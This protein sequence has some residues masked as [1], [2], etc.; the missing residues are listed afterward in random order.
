MLEGEKDYGGIQRKKGGGSCGVVRVNL[1]SDNASDFWHW[2]MCV[3]LG[4]RFH[5]RGPFSAKGLRQKCT[6]VAR[7]T[8]KRPGGWGRASGEECGRRWGHSDEYRVHAG[9]W[10]PMSRLGLFLLVNQGTPARFFSRGLT[11]SDFYLVI[12]MLC[13][14]KTVGGW[15]WRKHGDQLGIY[16]SSSRKIWR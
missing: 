8:A 16:F 3:Y 4:K 7:G 10:R 13:W 12:W 1:R 2:T 5:T 6:H 14:E 11:W 9:L 15:G